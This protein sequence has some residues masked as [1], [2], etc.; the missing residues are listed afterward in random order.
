[1]RSYYSSP[2]S[3]YRK[4]NFENRFVRPPSLTRRETTHL[5][6][7]RIRK[8]E[9]NAHAPTALTNQ[10]TQVLLGLRQLLPYLLP[11]A[12]TTSTPTQPRN[13]SLQTRN[14]NGQ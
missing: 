5:T 13:S 12:T 7:R 14:P 3:T 4:K 10:R 2:R 1:M 6:R 11:P 9:A 8:I